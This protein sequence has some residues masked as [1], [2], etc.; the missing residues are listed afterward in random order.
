MQTPLD[1]YNALI[2][3]GLRPYLYTWTEKA[4]ETAT[5]LGWGGNAK[6]DDLGAAMN[7]H[8]ADLLAL[9][10]EFGAKRVAVGFSK[11]LVV[12]SAEKIVTS[13]CRHRPKRRTRT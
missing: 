2:A 13:R 11:E 6:T 9:A 3:R 8:Y 7:L 1:L 12:D 4:G 5:Q 10:Q